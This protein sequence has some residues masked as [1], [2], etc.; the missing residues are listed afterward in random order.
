MPVSYRQNIPLPKAPVVHRIIQNCPSTAGQV[1]PV[2][3]GKDAR[4]RKI[5]LGSPTPELKS[6][7]LVELRRVTDNARPGDSLSIAKLAKRFGMPVSH[8]IASLEEL[9][10]DGKILISGD[11][12]NW[13]VEVV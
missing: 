6:M 5:N 7:V 12:P 3:I 11:L 4:Q 10:L 13:V 2:I 1:R 9:E 8:I